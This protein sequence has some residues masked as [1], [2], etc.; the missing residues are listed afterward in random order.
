M[1]NASGKVPVKAGDVL[2][3][4]AKYSEDAGVMLQAITKAIAP[5]WVLANTVGG[6]A[7]TD[8]VIRHN[9]AYFEEFCLRPMS[10]N[11]ATFED[12]AALIGRRALLTNPSPLAVLDSHP[13]KGDATDGRMQLGVLAYYYLL[14]DPETSY[15]MFFGGYEPGTT[16]QRHWSPAVACDVGK[17]KGV[18]SLWAN[19]TDPATAALTYRVYRRD[20]ENGLVLLKPL[21]YAR[22]VKEQAGQGDETA[23]KHELGGTYQLLKAD[24]TLAE[25][26][27]SVSLRNGEGAILIKKK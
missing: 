8:P 5:K 4:P 21:S 7:G 22:A 13:Q 25:P 15:L 19:G 14:A 18:W 11:W 3:S 20:Y 1:D 23:T 10:H 17:P 6:G 26:V 27:T 9:P 12:T 16:W 2:E 24:G